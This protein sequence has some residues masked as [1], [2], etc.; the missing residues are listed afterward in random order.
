MPAMSPTSHLVYLTPNLRNS[1]S[2]T[3]PSESNI[4]QFY[5]DRAQN[6]HLDSGAFQNYKAS[7]HRRELISTDLPS[8]QQLS[9]APELPDLCAAAQKGPL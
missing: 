5:L 4:P 2:S 1:L 6:I 9:P 8:K 3:S 7:Q